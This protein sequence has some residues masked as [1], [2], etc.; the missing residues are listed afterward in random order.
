MLLCHVLSAPIAWWKMSVLSN[1]EFMT[2]GLLREGIAVIVVSTGI[3]WTSVVAVILVES[4]VGGH[5]TSLTLLQTQAVLKCEKN[6]IW[7]IVSLRRAEFW[8]LFSFTQI[9]PA[10][11][12]CTYMSKTEGYRTFLW[13]SWPEGRDCMPRRTQSQRLMPIIW[14]VPEDTTIN[15][16]KKCIHKW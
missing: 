2:V 14:A 5:H 4:L 12:S 8:D 6:S 7:F 16:G 1:K 9:I 10:P 3:S 15:K 11:A 13:A